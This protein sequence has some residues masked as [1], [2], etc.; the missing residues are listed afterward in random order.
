MRLLLAI[1]Y[2]AEKFSQREAYIIVF[3]TMKPARAAWLLSSTMAPW[4][5]PDSDG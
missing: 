5:C 4:H 1:P 2:C 3:N